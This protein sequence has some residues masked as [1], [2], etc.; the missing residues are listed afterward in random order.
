[1]VEC[2]EGGGRRLPRS[3]GHPMPDM[4]RPA[5]ADAVRKDCCE[6]EDPTQ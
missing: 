6:S 3:K 5:E 1:M 2:V 4:E